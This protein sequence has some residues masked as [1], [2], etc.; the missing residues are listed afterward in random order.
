[1]IK[2]LI[3]SLKPI[4]QLALKQYLSY[5]SAD[6]KVNSPSSFNL[7]TD[8]DEKKFAN[9]IIRNINAEQKIGLSK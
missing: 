3:S 1:M 4:L 2:I 7:R 5:F 8:D 9:D 6:K